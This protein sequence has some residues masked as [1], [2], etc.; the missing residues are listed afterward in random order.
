MTAYVAKIPKK[1]EFENLEN[2]ENRENIIENYKNVFKD[3]ST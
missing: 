2:Y 3:N 1:L